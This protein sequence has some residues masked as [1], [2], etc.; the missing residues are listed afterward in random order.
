M[1][2][3]F[4]VQTENFNFSDQKVIT[5]LYNFKIKPLFDK[6]WRISESNR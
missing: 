4:V 5:L 1:S 2:K 3:N 6:K